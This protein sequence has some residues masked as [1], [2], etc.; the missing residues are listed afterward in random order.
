M[1]GKLGKYQMIG[2]TTFKGLVTENHLGALF[3]LQPQKASDLMVQLLAY[4]RGKTL[5]TFLSRF[6]VSNLA[7]QYGDILMKSY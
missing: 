2:P 1:A 6:P 7:A 3:Q 4:H 5:N